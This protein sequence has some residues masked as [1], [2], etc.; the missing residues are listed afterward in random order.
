MR[1]VYH[2][3][4]EPRKSPL[5]AN[6][7]M[8]KFEA[9]QTTAREFR[10]FESG[11]GIYQV[12]QTNSGQRFIVSLTEAKCSCKTFYEYQS[13]CSHAIAAARHEKVD[14]IS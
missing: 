5:L 7:F 4:K 10:V 12:E 13:P 6:I 1:M 8:A 11:N 14:P 9:R 3:F 2:R